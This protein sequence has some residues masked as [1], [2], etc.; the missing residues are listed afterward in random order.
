MARAISRN[1]RQG[2][3]IARAISRSDRQ[4]FLIARAISSDRGWA[5]RPIPDHLPP[6]PAWYH[7]MKRLV[8][9]LISTSFAIA[10]PAS[11]STPTNAS[12]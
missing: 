6:S 5:L 8:S 1:N 11:N 3:L 12:L 4:G 7:G 9:Q 10:K 2:V